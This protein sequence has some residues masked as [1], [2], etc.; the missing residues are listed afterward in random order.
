[1][2]QFL[3]PAPIARFMASMFREPSGPVRLLDPGAGVGSLTAAYVSEACARR[4]TPSE[5]S[6]TAYEIDPFLVPYLG[7]TLEMC[8]AHCNAAGL[9]FAYEVLQADF[10]EAATTVLQDDL[11]SQ[12]RPRFTAAILNPPYGKI[13]SNSP[14]RRLLRSVGIE[15]TNLYT[16]FLALAVRLL[17][18][19]GELVSITPRSFCNG[20]YFRPFRR[21]LLE[22]AALHRIHVF[23]SRDVAFRDDEVL[24]ENVILYAEK[25]KTRPSVVVVSSSTSPSGVD[26]TVRTV[27][28]E[29]VVKPSDPESF[30][31]VAPEENG[32]EIAD[33]M[34]RQPFSLAD[35]G[36]T[37]STGRVVDFRAKE[38]LRA[39]P[40]HDTAPLIYPFNFHHGYIQW[41]LRHNKKP[42]ALLVGAA[43]MDLLVPSE[44]YVLVKR[45][46]A[47]E[48]R[49]RV[50]AAVHDPA[51]I[52]ASLTGFEN[53]L[54]Y[55]HRAGR[56]IA[57]SLAKG[58]MLYLNST[59]VDSYFRQFSGHTQVNAT[60]LRSL[61]YPTRHVL[62]RLGSRMTDVLP[63]Q[64]EVD[65]WVEEE[66]R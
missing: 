9:P 45:F 39:E 19:G 6:V 58:L 55:F 53:H 11:F 54:N 7:R 59:F 23:E 12:P 20:P 15:T 26:A 33:R 28:Y 14:T 18:D 31:H 29:Q 36:L 44:V 42:V 64:Q 41:P 2:G 10:I 3:T 37:V 16:A 63:G 38:F 1:M 57:V 62:E 46:T 50:V 32:H 52:G 5:I 35:L 51:R 61:K 25:T 34:A 27:G 48:E 40:E 47:K 13:N 8:R 66:L 22:S 30:I 49:R 56:G 4:I 43:T 60:D 24:Q 21:L 65:R 17:E